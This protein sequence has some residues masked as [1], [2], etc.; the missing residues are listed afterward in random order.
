MLIQAVGAGEAQQGPYLVLGPSLGRVSDLF[1]VQGPGSSLLPG[2]SAD[3]Q[4]RAH[5]FPGRD[6]WA[7][8]LPAPVG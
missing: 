4:Q 5:G 3:A 1:R 7:W 2:R 8:G 6:G